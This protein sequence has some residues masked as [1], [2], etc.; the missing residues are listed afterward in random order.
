MRD[1]WGRSI[2]LLGSGPWGRHMVGENGWAGAHG[3][4]AGEKGLEHMD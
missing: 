4:R 1:R 2:D 3:L